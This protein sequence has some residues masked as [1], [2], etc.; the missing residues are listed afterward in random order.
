ME[1]P[2][3]ME[4]LQREIEQVQDDYYAD[5][6]KN[7][8]FK[9]QQKFDCAKQVSSHIPLELL[10]NQYCRVLPNT[11]MVY[12]D[13]PFMKTFASPEIFDIMS[14]H[15][16]QLFLMAKDAFG[17]LDVHLNLDGFTVSAAERYK[18]I[19][20]SFCDKC[21]RNNTGFSTIIDR[22]MIYN[23]PATIDHIK[24]LFMPFMLED[25]KRKAQLISK[26]DSEPLLRELGVI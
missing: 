2:R 25:V 17:T 13:Y 1:L 14:D 26:R 18:Q 10:L 3:E 22:F 21:L 11:Q 9:K 12:I 23:T 24:P 6:G 16:F 19:V 7:T 20:I 4:E 5:H 15:I 8:F